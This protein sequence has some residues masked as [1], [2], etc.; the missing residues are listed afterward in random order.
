M[1]Q[2]TPGTPPRPDQP[3]PDMVAAVRRL[4]HS[5]VLVINSEG[6]LGEGSA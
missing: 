2:I 6:N 1:N 4:A 5:S 3:N